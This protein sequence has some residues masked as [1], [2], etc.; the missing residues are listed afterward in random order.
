VTVSLCIV[1]RNEAHFI[2]RAIASARALVDQIV[3]VDTGSTDGTPNV[4]RRA[5]AEVTCAPWPGDLGKAHDLPIERA[6]GDWILALDADEALDP[7]AVARLPRLMQEPAD[8]YRFTVRNY[9]YRPALKWRDADPS[10]PLTLGAAGWSPSWAVRLFRN[11]SRYRNRGR[12]H[13]S[14]QWAILAAGGT[15]ADTDLPIHHYGMLRCDRQKGSF[16]L[17]LA[18][19]EA[20]DG[21]MSPRAWVELGVVQ[22]SAGD[23]TSARASFERAFELSGDPA[24]AFHLGRYLLNDGDPGA[25][26][27]TLTAAINANPRDDSRDFD[28]A[29]AWEELS[30]AREAT[31]DLEGA[32]DACR[33]ALALRPDSPIAL[34]NLAGLLIEA[35]R[36][37]EAQQSIERL[38]ARYRGF[39]HGWSLHAALALARRDRATAR[40]SLQIAIDCDPASETTG[41]ALASLTTRASA[42]TARAATTS[43]PPQCSKPS[44]CIRPAWLTRWASSSS[45]PKTRRGRSFLS[46][47]LA[48]CVRA[49]RPAFLHSKEIRWTTGAPS[50]ESRF[51]SSRA[52]RCIHQI[53]DAA[54]TPQPRFSC[55]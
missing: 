3:V 51:D 12:L 43:A 4:A 2:G 17:Q 20:C 18:G 7:S 11:D 55:E 10:D 25:A 30:R 47:A 23:T 5:G 49:T 42:E 41:Q 48:P 40:R 31:G 24:A 34:T 39:S 36:L 6:T 35:G 46:D 52:S 13:Q 45:G 26:A 22:M 1:A 53:D 50:G 38:L 15:V 28:L 21:P 29:D 14:V 9:E 16:Y 33:A 27:A 44:T 8:G 54:V 32:S 19:A 37:D